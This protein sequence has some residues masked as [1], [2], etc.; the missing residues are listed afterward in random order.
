MSTIARYFTPLNDAR[1]RVRVKAYR[2]NL[3][4]LPSSR[5]AE[6]EEADALLL[7]CAGDLRADTRNVAGF[8][9]IAW[10]DEGNIVGQMHN[11][12]PSPYYDEDI[13]Q[14]IG[15]WLREAMDEQNAA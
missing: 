15:A 2:H 13:F 5:D 7:A 1:C 6:L 11:T 4:C 3:V 9:M 14:H 8:A 12:Q 10:D